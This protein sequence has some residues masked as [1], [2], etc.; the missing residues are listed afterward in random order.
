MHQST[1]R[2]KKARWLKF[3]TLLVIGSITAYAWHSPQPVANG[4]TW[5]G[6]TLGTIGALLIVWL[7]WF[8]IRKRSYKNPRGTVQGWLSAHVYL[9][10]A[11]IIV[12]TLHTGF[13]FAWNLHTLAYVLMCLV[14]VSGFWGIVVYVRYPTELSSNRQNKTQSELLAQLEDADRQVVTATQKLD[15]SLRDAADSSIELTSLGGS[16][17]RQLRKRDF[18]TVVIDGK[19]QTNPNQRAV[20]SHFAALMGSNDANLNASLRTAIEALNRRSELLERIRKDIRIRAMLDI[21]LMLHIP[22]TIALIT[23]LTAHVVV[24]FLYW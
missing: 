17:F 19:E 16:A 4:G 6:Y 5:L 9:G 23:A 21:W 20:I 18:S 15:T 10:S 3:A 14:I 2:Y 8:G 11:L 7:A 22:A 1:L 24:V 13:Q 12:G